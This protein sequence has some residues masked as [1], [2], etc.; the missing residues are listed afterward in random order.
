MLTTG[1][2]GGTADGRSTAVLTGNIWGSPVG[3]WGSHRALLLFP[4][5]QVVN[6][7]YSAVHDISNAGRGLTGF[8]VNASRDLV[9]NKLTSKLGAATAFANTTATGGGSHMGTEVNAELRYNL[10]VFLTA[11]VN[12]GYLR[13][14]DFYDA[15]AATLQGTRPRDPWTLFASLSWLMF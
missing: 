9:P 7:Y 11:A 5:P 10:G 14:G 13:L 2:G 1:D 4:D 12:A 8:A 6:R 15:P 3:I